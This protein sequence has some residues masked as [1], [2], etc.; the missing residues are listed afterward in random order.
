MGRRWRQTEHSVNCN[1]SFN[2][3]RTNS[4]WAS[5]TCYC[6]LAASKMLKRKMASGSMFSFRP[7]F[8]ALR[9][10]VALYSSSHWSLI[11]NHFFHEC[12]SSSGTCCSSVSEFCDE[13]V[14]KPIKLFIGDINAHTHTVDL[15]CTTLHEK[16]VQQYTDRHRL[17]KQGQLPSSRHG[18]VCAAL[19]TNTWPTDVPTERLPAAPSWPGPPKITP[20]SQAHPTRP[21]S[22]SRHR[23]GAL[24]GRWRG[25]NA[26]KW[27]A[28]SEIQHDVI[29]EWN[30]VSNVF[31][32][33]SRIGQICPSL[34]AADFRPMQWTVHCAVCSFRD[35]TWR[36]VVQC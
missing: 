7:A 11:T 12:L 6:K 8:Y 14:Q 20:R 2:Q 16:Y 30:F 32:G 26:V 1:A 25:N 36:I 9:R 19:N 15:L 27:L 21:W 17:A 28:H 13:L 10:S 24:V 4:A 5:L 23:Q 34:F 35:E 29:L 33:W 18:R 22:V 3:R 31:L